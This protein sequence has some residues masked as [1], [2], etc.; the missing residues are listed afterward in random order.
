[1]ALHARKMSYEHE[2]SED[3][4]HPG[5]ATFKTSNSPPPAVSDEVRPMPMPTPST[6][7]F[8]GLDAI[9]HGGFVPGFGLWTT[10][11][12]TGTTATQG[13]ACSSI[14]NVPWRRQSSL[15]LQRG[16]S[17]DGPGT[18][19]LNAV[20]SEDGRSEI[21]RYVRSSS[22]TSESSAN[23]MDSPNC[24]D[25]SRDSSALSSL[26]NSISAEGLEES[27]TSCAK[28]HEGYGLHEATLSNSHGSYEMCGLCGAQLATVALGNC[29]HR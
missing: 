10:N 24:S 5:R 14:T 1:M 13:N 19:P 28:P 26:E 25:T 18:L 29:G 11:E 9:Q 3:T 22:F 4:E 2:S 7:A 21:T 15:P 6:S 20:Y 23:S 17:A 27:A 8:T 16:A 12:R